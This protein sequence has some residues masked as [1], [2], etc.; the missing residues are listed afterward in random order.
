M[1]FAF[2]TRWRGVANT[3]RHPVALCELAMTASSGCPFHAQPPSAPSPIPTPPGWPPGPSAGLTG[4]GLLAQLSRDLF[5]TLERW[6]DTYGDV[7]HLR[8][9]PEHQIVVT[10]PALLRELLVE[11]HDALIRWQR[12]MQVFGRLYGHSV[13]IAEGQVWRDKRLALAPGFSRQ[14]A[15]D[16]VPA[17]VS[18]AERQLARWPQQHPHWRIDRALITL[19]METITQLLFSCTLGDAAESTA[20]AVQTV[21]AASQAELY[22][23]A[24]WPDWLPWKRA[25]RRA[26]LLLD[27][28]IQRQLHARLALADSA[29]PDDLLS[30]WLRLHHAN[31]TDWPLAAVRDECMTT[32]LAGHE[33]TA[34][35]LAWWAWDL[36][37]HPQAQADARTE[38]TRVLQGRP[39]CA[40][41]LPALTTLRHTLEETLRLHPAAPVLSTRRAIRPVTL[42]PWQ[43]PAGTLFL[44]PVQLLHHDPRQFDAPLGFCPERFATA[45]ASA[46]PAYQP[47]GRGPRVCLGQH[48]AMTEMTLI[49]A[50]LLQRRQL[51]VADG[52]SAPRAVLKVSLRP[53][54]GVYVRLAP[55]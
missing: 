21:L 8:I 10:D 50:M 43:L 7:V 52:V 48:L 25:K 53:E 5:G 45:P 40:A 55:V 26:R 54:P 14:A 39:P 29:W 13:F 32:F 36:A 23:P 38:V 22:W 34:A 17:M 41:D 44:L 24:S 46:H 51:S 19:T 49:A 28:V 37:C 2:K 30:R 20:Q 15:W 42:G 33:T 9:W 1:S 4:W 35:T 12:G 27:G 47:F 31:P 3:A 16:A 18:V 6:R 11:Q